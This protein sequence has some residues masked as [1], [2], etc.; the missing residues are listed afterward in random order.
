[1]RLIASA[2]TLWASAFGSAGR[3]LPR[4]LPF[5]QPPSLAFSRAASAFFF[6]VTLPSSAP[7]FISFPQCGHFIRPQN[8]ELLT[9]LHEEN[10]SSPLPFLLMNTFISVHHTVTRY[11]ARGE[12]IAWTFEARVFDRDANYNLLE[13]CGHSHRSPDA[14]NRCKRRFERKYAAK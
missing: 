5:G 11:N 3:R 6:D 1:M 7:T 10:Q 14:A 12:A 8:T 4:F 13:L 9:M 2:T